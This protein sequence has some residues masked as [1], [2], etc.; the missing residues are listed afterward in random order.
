MSVYHR[1]VSAALLGA[2]VLI[3]GA[4]GLSGQDRSVFDYIGVPK[5]VPCEA[6]PEFQVARSGLVS[7][8]AEFSSLSVH[9]LGLMVED[10]TQQRAINALLGVFDSTS[11][12]ASEMTTLLTL[13][14]LAARERGAARVQAGGVLLREI[15]SAVT[16]SANMRAGY[17]SY[18]EAKEEAREFTPIGLREAGERAVALMRD[19]EGQLEEL[20]DLLESWGA[21]IK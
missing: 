1:T 15:R 7:L 10:L 8:S 17:E 6:L 21:A 9:L 12:N 18:I 13:F 16:M 14:C 19:T 4:S 20:S 2:G 11:D 3:L 5:L